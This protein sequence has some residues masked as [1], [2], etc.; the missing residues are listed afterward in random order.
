MIYFHIETSLEKYF[1]DLKITQQEEE[2]V[3]ENNEEEDINECKKNK[4]KSRTLL[5]I[6]KFLRGTIYIINRQ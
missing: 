1:E 6:H 3:F 2:E 4:S 5:L